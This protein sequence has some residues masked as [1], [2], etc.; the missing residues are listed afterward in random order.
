MSNLF[1]FDEPEIKSK[2]VKLTPIE[3]MEKAEIKVP[4][5]PVVR[6]A[7]L[8]IYESSKKRRLFTRE[9]IEDTFN[10]GGVWLDT[11][12]VLCEE[13]GWCVEMLDGSFK[14]RIKN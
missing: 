12:F 14:G 5:S 4:I 10:V 13:M 11:A 2:T 9:Y 3:L 7:I 6:K 1:E 8:A